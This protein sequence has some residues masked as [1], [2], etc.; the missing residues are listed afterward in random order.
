MASSPHPVETTLL[1]VDDDRSIRDLLSRSLRGH[2]YHVLTAAD[3]AEM[4]RLLGKAQVDLILLDIMMPG[5]D[6]ISAGSRIAAAGGPPIVFLSALG[7]EHDRIAGLDVGASHYLPK[8][9][10]PREILATVRAA[11]RHRDMPEPLGSRLYGFAGWRINLTSHELHDP[12]G[13]L[14]DL[15]DGEFAV[16]R[17]FVERPRRV[18]ARDALLDA[19]RGPDSASFDRAIDVQVSRLRRKLRASGD[20]LIRTV[21]NEGY[22]FTPQVERL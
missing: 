3:V 1:V 9:C 18:L 16:L 10:S 15:T 4:E 8:P 12:E 17:A 2:G 22:L 5:E 20:V 6:G 11:L 13:I 21:R 19:A 7:E 14:V